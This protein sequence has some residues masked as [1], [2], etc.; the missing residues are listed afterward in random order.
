ME[1]WRTLSLTNTDYN[2]TLAS[3]IYIQIVFYAKGDKNL[4]LSKWIVQI[5]TRNSVLQWC[6]K[7]IA[8][9][10]NAKTHIF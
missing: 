8:I 9:N 3:Q 4:I 10:V 6:Q 2:V 7:L 1:S 5:Y